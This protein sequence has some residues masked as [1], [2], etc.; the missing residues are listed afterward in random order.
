MLTT[1]RGSTI[2]YDVCRITQELLLLRLRTNNHGIA[3]FQLRIFC[4]LTHFRRNTQ[5]TIAFFALGVCCLSV[6][7]EFNRW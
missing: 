6:G 4:E 7:Y 1:A 2:Y 3:P 5:R